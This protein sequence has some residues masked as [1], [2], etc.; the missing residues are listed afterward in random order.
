MSSPNLFLT[1][2]V[3]TPRTGAVFTLQR[4]SEMP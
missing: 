3:S 4:R 2:V 1:S